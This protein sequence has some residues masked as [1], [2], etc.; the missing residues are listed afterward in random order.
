[1]AY[2]LNGCDYAV[3]DGCKTVDELARNVCHDLKATGIDVVDGLDAAECEGRYPLS[4]FVINRNS[5][6]IAIASLKDGAMDYLRHTVKGRYPGKYFLCSDGGDAQDGNFRDE[7]GCVMCSPEPPKSNG[8]TRLRIY[9]MEPKR[10]GEMTYAGTVEY[11]PMTGDLDF[12]KSPICRTEI[13]VELY[14]CGYEGT[15]IRIS[16]IKNDQRHSYGNGYTSSVR[17]VGTGSEEEI[18]KIVRQNTELG[19]NTTGARLGWRYGFVLSVPNLP[20][21]SFLIPFD[22]RLVFDAD[23]V[24]ETWNRPKFGSP[25]NDMAPLNESQ[26]EEAKAVLDQLID[27]ALGGDGRKDNRYRR[28]RSDNSGELTAEYVMYMCPAPKGERRPIGHIMVGV[29]D[30]VHREYGELAICRTDARF[31]IVDMYIRVARTDGGWYYRR[32]MER[33]MTS[34]KEVVGDVKIIRGTLEAAKNLK[35]RY[36]AD[37]AIGA[38]V[39]GAAISIPASVLRNVAQMQFGSEF[40]EWSYKMGFTR[41]ADSVCSIATSRRAWN[42]VTSMSD[43]IPGYLEGAKSIYTCFGL[44]KSWG[45][46]VFDICQRE[47]KDF[48]EGLLGPVIAATKMAWDLEVALTGGKPSVACIPQRAVEYA[49]V[50]RKYVTDL[51]LFG[52]GRIQRDDFVSGA[53][54]NDPIGLADAIRSYNRMLAKLEKMGLDNW[55]NKRYITETFEAYCQIREIG[56][57]PESHGVL[58]EYGLPEENDEAAEE[59]IQRR[60]EA[61][62]AVVGNFQDRI[63]AKARQEVEDKFAAQ[64]AKKHW[65]ECSDEEVCKDFVFKLPSSIYG[66]TE[67]LSIEWEGEHQRNCVFNS[68]SRKLAEGDY[69]VILMRKRRRQDESYVTIGISKAGIVDQTYAYR[70]SQISVEAAQAIRAWMRKVNSRGNGTLYFKGN[71]GG[72][73]GAIEPGA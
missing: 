7:I 27:K 38:K 26:R 73:N 66:D 63:N 70:D 43:I 35:N 37:A 31:T 67:P 58:F 62:Q 54:P 36:A 28:Y 44:P 34:M 59:M 53:Y 11:N 51:G 24:K 55:Q 6:E 33:T 22:D 41:L 14:D 25:E 61:A 71:P 69:T 45:K 30:G 1:M 56:E 47:N 49:T 16:L 17:V 68:Y 52:N 40:V 19:L 2:N 15:D 4:Y 9:Y 39:E 32:C 8:A 23:K 12:R 46:A 5:P 65:M 42:R 57:D 72:W 64:V 29:S 10:A 50:C 48:D 21:P 3:Y 18:D 13:N 60:C 20:E